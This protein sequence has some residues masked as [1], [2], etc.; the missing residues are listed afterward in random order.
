[1]ESTTAEQ[2]QPLLSL[3]ARMLGQ[4]M[5]P[6]TTWRWIRIGVKVGDRRVKLRAVKIGGKLF[7]TPDDVQ[8][9]ID[10]QNPPTGETDD[11]EYERSPE[12]ERRLTAAGLL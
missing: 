9:F 10:E 3:L 4:R 1:M 11:D 6:T 5:S 7:T 12:T 2:F 8:R